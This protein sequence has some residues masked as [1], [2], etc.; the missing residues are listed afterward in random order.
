[1]PTYQ[2]CKIKADKMM[3]FIKPTCSYCRKTVELLKQLPIKQESLAFV[4]ITAHCDTNVIQDYLQ[5]LTG[6]R[7][8]LR[9]LLDGLIHQD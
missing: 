5:Q 4:N 9:S 1:M 7:T 3:V 2:L 8:V 6:V